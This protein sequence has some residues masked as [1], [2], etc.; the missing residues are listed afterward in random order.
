MKAQKPAMKVQRH[1][2]RSDDG[3]AFI[4]DPEGGP[5]HTRDDL[6]ETL[7][8]GFLQGATQDEDGE[9]AALDGLVPE[10]IGGPFV[11]TSASAEFA[12]GTDA[13]NPADAE[14]EAM[15]R[16]VGSLSLR[17]EVDRYREGDETETE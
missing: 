14:R 16:P 4:P 12:D 5:A 9:D 6:A 7:A 17:P 15:P 8:E 13:S 2:P 3:N 11:E 10:E 1:H